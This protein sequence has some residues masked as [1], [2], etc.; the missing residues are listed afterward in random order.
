MII[1]ESEI[2][3]RI[4][5]LESKLQENE[6]IYPSLSHDLYAQNKML[7]QSFKIESQLEA[8]HYVLGESYIY[9]H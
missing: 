2:R 8:L 9:K 6:D 1:S 3:T 5:E 4:K 7:V